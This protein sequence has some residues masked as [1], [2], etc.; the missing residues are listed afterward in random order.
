IEGSCLSTKIGSVSTQQPKHADGDNLITLRDLFTHF[1]NPLSEVNCI[2]SIVSR[3]SNVV[4]ARLY[5]MLM[6]EG[7]RAVPYIPVSFYPSVGG[8]LS[9]KKKFVATLN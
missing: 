7:C 4:S 3:T 9:V 8:R 5:A 1:L 6:M 2:K